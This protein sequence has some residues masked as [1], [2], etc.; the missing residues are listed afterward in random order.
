MDEH[1]PSVSDNER[2]TR[3]RALIESA[4][5][6]AAET[7][8]PRGRGVLRATSTP[9]S[10]P[11]YDLA[12]EIHRGGQGVVYQA[13]QRTTGRTVAV[14]IMRE[15]PFGGPRDHARFEREV[16]VLAQLSH[17]NIV[18][19]L[20]SGTAAGSAYFV[21]DF[22]D[23][24]PFDQYVIQRMDLPA[25]PSLRRGK[26]GA[27]V[28]ETLRLFVKVCDAVHAAHL[29]GVV[30]RD[31]KPNNV[32][33]DAAGE[34]HIL[35]FGLAK[36]DAPARDGGE[37][38]AATTAGQ[39]VGSLP[40]ASPEQAAGDSAQIDV[41]TDVYSLGI[42]LYQTLTGRFPYQVTGM[43]HDVLQR[44]MHADP[45][46]PSRLSARPGA[47]GRLLPLPFLTTL[48]RGSHPSSMDDELETIVLKCLSKDRERRYQ[49]AGELARDVR[50]YLADEPIEAK[51]DSG[52]YV[53]R[54]TLRRHRRS[55]VIAAAFGV[56]V[57]GATIA[58]TILYAQ[59]G[60][61]LAQVK[62]ER[63]K[64]VAS[65]A[66]AG[67]RLVQSEYEFYVA[68]IAAAGAAIAANDGGAALARLQ[69]APAD[70]RNW[71]WHYLI[72]QADQSIGTWHGPSALIT[73]RVGLSPD[74]LFVGA[75][76]WMENQH[77]EV[78]I[79][80]RAAGKAVAEFSVDNGFAAPFKFLDDGKY[81]LYCNPD[82]DLARF[83]LIER[84]EV[85]HHKVS[86]LG[87][88]QIALEFSPNGRVLLTAGMAEYRLW[89]LAADQ[90]LHVLPIWQG[91]WTT[92]VDYDA[93][94][95][96]LAAVV[97]DQTIVLWDALTGRTLAQTKTGRGQAHGVA[98]SSDGKLLATAGEGGVLTLWELPEQPS[99]SDGESEHDEQSLR[100]IRDLHGGDQRNG[101]P[102][103]SPDNA[104]L[105]VP[106]EDKTVRIWDV[107]KGEIQTTLLGHTTGAVCTAFSKDGRFVVSGAR[108]GW[109]KLWDLQKANS[110]H[111]I[112]EL[113][114][115]L[116]SVAF[117]PDGTRLIALCA[118]GV[119]VIDIASGQ[120]LH[121]IP[122]SPT[123][124]FSP[125]L[126]GRDGLQA[127]LAHVDG[128][129]STY[130]FEH[131]GAARVIGVHEKMPFIAGVASAG[132]L[133]SADPA[134]VV[135][136]NWPARQELRR[137]AGPGEPLRS[138]VISPDASRVAMGLM[139]GGLVMQDT[140]TGRLAVIEQP[141]SSVVAGLAFSPDGRDLAIG[142]D[143]GIVKLWD[144]ATR[145]VKWSASPH[146]G[147]VWSVAFSPDGSRLAVGGRDR[148]VRVLDARTGR[149]LLA[150]R[151]PTGTVM[152]VAFSPDGR[153]IAAGSWACE[154]FVWDA[155]Q[156]SEVDR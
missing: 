20:D 142:S 101:V 75:S 128:R 82:G 147:D 109:V 145:R 131:D 105:A 134:A 90:L 150:L 9:D 54:K 114:G 43:F 22:V 111:S 50:H 69:T 136:W 104:L 52:W 76:F 34:P 12:E 108:E 118:E 141:R 115:S 66:L 14:K 112:R 37:D 149:E 17:P 155:S 36:L 24:V 63:D 45:I 70:L 47:V 139:N 116:I 71:E 84:R 146:L 81:L 41:R 137:F 38:I 107:A 156:P 39:F 2:R 26:G 127:T 122:W 130:D 44:I 60:S 87:K 30:H 77:G 67:Q 74:N 103:F 59:Q 92:V 151:G 119:C 15:G 65:E 91:A 117:T 133:A 48:F 32:L 100:A 4:R 99:D 85:S 29:N 13:R 88:E 110:I 78:A 18:G 27:T 123:H 57:F 94:G 126:L 61:L 98:F 97:H 25:T 23:G 5:G 10:V 49:T 3:V 73:G 28:A 95:T 129:V 83:D 96:R 120:R 21:M 56:L 68:N 138:F 148:S 72:R 106:S 62:V 125:V 124:H 154:L 113:P 153:S 35:D 42:M 46:L 51:R 8:L 79:W 1:D 11:G 6:Q 144:I 64:A 33:V 55:A 40:W 31:L 86:A 152:C 132:I 121:Q 58:L 140:R 80:S 93:T 19:V 89:D 16:Q 143:E 135:M 102:S 53:L 7:T